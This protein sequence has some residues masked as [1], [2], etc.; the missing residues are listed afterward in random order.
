MERFRHRLREGGEG[1]ERFPLK[2]GITLL[3][4]KHFVAGP[5]FGHRGFCSPDHSKP[6]TKTGEPLHGNRLHSLR[7]AYGQLPAR[8][9]LFEREGRT[10]IEVPQDPLSRIQPGRERPG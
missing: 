5:A 8:T 9:Q 2:E 1:K 6:R 3:K 4:S 7:P 10:C